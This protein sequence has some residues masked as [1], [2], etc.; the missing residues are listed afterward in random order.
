[1]KEYI[2]N[3]DTLA[4]VMIDKVTCLIIEENSEFF[5][6]LSWLEIVNNSC[7]YYGSSYDGRIEA[8][9]NLL[10]KDYKLPI[11]VS[12]FYE[13][14]MFP[15]GSKQSDMCTWICL[16][17]MENY[18][19]EENMVEFIF[20]CKRRYK[21]AIGKRSFETQLLKAYDLNRIINNRYKKS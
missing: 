7:L 2:I 12:E 8:S 4:I 14:L 5:I 10:G 20:K 9:K 19:V 13:I 6:N 16:N 15:I 3:K 11:I 21:V 18:I 17:K 1:M